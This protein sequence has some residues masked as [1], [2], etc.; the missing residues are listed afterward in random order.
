MTEPGR[1]PEALLARIREE[2]ARAAR[3]RLKLFFGANPGVGKTFAMLEDA[4]ARRAEG[5]DVVVGVVETHGRSETAALVTG[6][7]VLPRRELS[8][9][10]VALQEFDLDG[11]LKRRP[12]L[13]LIDELAHSNAPGSRH[14]RRWQD[15]EELLAAGISVYSTLNVQHLESLNDVVAQITGVQVRETV[16]D[17]VFDAADD[18]ELAD[19]TPDDLLA[20][21]QAGKVY[22]A[23]QAELA[24][25][26]FFR[27]G[28]LIALRELALRRVAERVDAQMQGY[29][30]AH[31]I[32]DVWPAGERILVCVGTT[33]SSG[34]LVRAG[35]RIATT[36][37]CDW[38]VV[39]VETLGARPRSAVESEALVETM[40]LADE[41]GA[42]TVTLQGHSVSEEILAYAQ[43]HNITRM[44]VGKPARRRLRDLLGGSLVDRLV[45]GSGDVDVYVI[46]GVEDRPRRRL[47]FRR[48]GSPAREYVFALVAVTLASV[49]GWLVFR[50]LSV[51]D[52]AMVYL[53]GAMTVAARCGRGP[54]VLAALL[55]IA[56]FDFLF[57]DPILTFVVADLRYLLTFGT[58]LAT[59][60][61]ISGFTLRSREQAEAARERERRT[62]ALYALSRDLANTRARPDIV[63]VIRRHLADTFDCTAQLLAPGADGTLEPLEPIA[64]VPVLDEKERS[65]AD[66]VFRRGEMAGAGTATLPGAAALHLPLTGAGGVVGVLVVAS[67]DLDRFQ[68]PAQR[69]LLET[70]AGQ[71]AV[72]LERVALAERTQQARLEVEAE[73][74]RTSLLSSLSHDLRTPLGVITGAASSLRDTPDLPGET[75][76]DLLDSILDESQ[77]MNRLI[78]NLL[79]MVRVE[80]GSLEV[81]KEWQPLEDAIGVALLRMDERM[82]GHPVEV[83]L[84]PDLPLV[85]LDA[86]LLEQVFINLLEN[87]AR[88]T[89][90]GSPIEI[91]ARETPGGVTVSVADRGPGLPPG[92]GDRIFEK[93]YR[94]PQ[95]EPGKGVGL[96]LTICRGIVSAHG[97]RIWAEPRPG[98]GSMFNFTLP[99]SGPAPL[100]IPEEPEPA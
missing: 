83:H 55:S 24:R 82:Q 91:S 30:Q 17:S 52:V 70:F 95:A 49:V 46:T 47:T 23:E 8:H 9:R 56:L 84:P 53:L 33:P 64:T 27:K 10:G 36:L 7:E 68:L 81:Q 90:P 26:R 38:V 4:R 34:R 40:Q 54:S 29:R 43:A 75:R 85:P 35:R 58:M 2:E 60:L 93:F 66:W 31:G 57:V 32:R 80:T 41:F 44:L 100:P 22:L 99:L 65:V 11:A 72:A 74:L 21:L 87:A 20:R 37:R 39:H 42:R 69:Y 59:A 15:V 25:E 48:P 71:A 5:V 45:R 96:G 6:L 62:A 18:V 3:G 89:P 98:G 14:E 13:I 50:R 94:G 86:V 97:G 76:R 16:P 73:R 79:D 92:E 61:V 77:R 28:N 63:S 1:D 12:A 78:R 51:T 19:L 88:Y 67:P